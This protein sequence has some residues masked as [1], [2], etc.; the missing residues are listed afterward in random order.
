MKRKVKKDSTKTNQEGEVKKKE[1][2]NM[3]LMGIMIGA[4]LTIILLG[5]LAQAKTAPS[6]L[7]VGVKFKPEECDRKSTKGDK[8]DMHYT[9]TLF[10]D[11]TKFDSSLDRGQPFSFT[12]GTGQVIKGW[13]Q[14]LLGMCVGEKRRLVN[15]SSYFISYSSSRK[16]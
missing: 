3:K 7:Q 16:L 2:I 11:G 5:A 4:L 14:G 6:K 10:D 1:G 8:L 15:L 12:L 13:D 9:G